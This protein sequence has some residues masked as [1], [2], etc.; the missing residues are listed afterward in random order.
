MAPGERGTRPGLPAQCRT[1]WADPR[2]TCP[3]VPCPQ[4]QPTP[5]QV[6]GRGGSS[7]WDGTVLRSRAGCPLPLRVGLAC[8]TAGPRPLC[9]AGLSRPCFWTLLHR[10]GCPDVFPQ[11]ICAASVCAVRVSRVCPSGPGPVSTPSS[12]G[13]RPAGCQLCP[14]L[15][16]PEPRP[17]QRAEPRAR[18]G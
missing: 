5:G 18:P 11:P 12:S 8:P 4:C 10:E 13:K 17:G 14:R 15:P 9:Q 16:E 7:R 2:A 6:C 1:R 3:P